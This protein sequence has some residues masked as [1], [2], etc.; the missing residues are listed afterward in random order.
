MKKNVKFKLIK[1]CPTINIKQ[2]IVIIT[3][4]DTLVF[5]ISLILSLTGYYGKPILNQEY[6]LGPNIVTLYNFGAKCRY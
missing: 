2:F 4:I 3:I 5:T 1:G 6:F